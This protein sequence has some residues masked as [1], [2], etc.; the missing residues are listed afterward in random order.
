[1]NLASRLALTLA[2]GLGLVTPESRSSDKRGAEPLVT[3]PD[4][5]SSQPLVVA[6]PRIEPTAPGPSSA[7]P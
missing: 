1:M 7:P 2:V 3:P 4:E 5:T 6:D